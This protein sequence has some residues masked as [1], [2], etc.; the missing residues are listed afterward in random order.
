MDPATGVAVLPFY[1]M[2]E[3]CPATWPHC[4]MQ[5]SSLAICWLCRLDTVVLVLYGFESMPTD[6]LTDISIVY[7]SFKTGKRTIHEAL[8]YTM[9]TDLV[10]QN[11]AIKVGC[12]K[13]SE[14][15]LALVG[16]YR[17]W[18]W[19]AIIKRTLT[20]VQVEGKTQILEQ[21]SAKTKSGLR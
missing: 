8:K 21:S 12:S 7:L 10:P 20:S 19:N 3:A 18:V 5:S 1:N 13:T 17:L 15:Q 4:L 6:F 11:A 2:V 16:R 9:A 14:F